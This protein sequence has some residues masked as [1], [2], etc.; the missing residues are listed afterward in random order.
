MTPTRTSSDWL[1][2]AVAMLGPLALCAVH[3]ARAPNVSI[4][5]EQ[6]TTCPTPPPA[7]EPQEALY[8][9]EE[10]DGGLIC[11]F[12]ESPV[13]DGD[14]HTP[15]PNTAGSLPFAFVHH[16]K[17]ILHQDAEPSWGAGP[18][19]GRN[20]STAAHFDDYLYGE[21]SA[22]LDT[23]PAQFR[24][25]EG[26]PIDVYGARG[27]LCE[28]QVGALAVVVEFNGLPFFSEHEIMPHDDGS[29]D[30]ETGDQVRAALYEHEDRWLVADINL[31]PS[32]EDAV[33]A[34]SAALPAPLMWTSEYGVTSKRHREAFFA[35]SEARLR[36]N[37]EQ[38]LREVGPSPIDLARWA[39]WDS[40]ARSTYQRRVYRDGAG[41]KRVLYQSMGDREFTCGDGFGEANSEVNLLKA[42][43]LAPL[44]PLE[45]LVAPPLAFLDIDG[46]GHLESLIQEGVS[47]TSYQLLNDTGEMLWSNSR[48]F[49]GCPC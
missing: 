9:H 12:D 49:Y 15:A 13:A 46:D 21:K 23:I 18:L 45:W 33:F 20:G 42:G 17:L 32:C 24:D 6:P 39:D 47:S 5:S 3:L 30:P 40:F 29:V 10:H 14:E 44:P 19:R 28:A 25:I 34:R 26:Q 2:Y 7:D 43:G 36:D 31:P 38:Y 37:Y 16:G 35:T 11:R 27:K 8:E 48:P 1:P 4:P 41:A 22:D